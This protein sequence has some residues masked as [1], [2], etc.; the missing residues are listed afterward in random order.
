MVSG[1]VGKMHPL[2]SELSPSG[3][4]KLSDATGT[5]RSESVAGWYLAATRRAEIVIG[6]AASRGL[7]RPVRS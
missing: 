7:S 1:T 3:R 5:T 6:L 4:P 2:G